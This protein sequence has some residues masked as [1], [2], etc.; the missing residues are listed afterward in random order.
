MGAGRMSAQFALVVTLCAAV[1]AALF[2][3][4]VAR[5]G[6]RGHGGDGFCALSDARPCDDGLG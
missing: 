6:R 5:R 1:V 2:V 3:T 4:N